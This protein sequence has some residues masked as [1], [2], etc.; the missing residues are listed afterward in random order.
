MNIKY[1][2]YVLMIEKINN[3][4]GNFTTGLGNIKQESIR[5]FCHMNIDT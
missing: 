2:Y 1:I 3:G 4:F 5:I